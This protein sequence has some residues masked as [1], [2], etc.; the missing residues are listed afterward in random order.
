MKRLVRIGKWVLG[1]VSVAA[2]LAGCG[3][4]GGSDSPSS[5]ASAP[6]SEAAAGG[7]GAAP[8]A[9]GTAATAAGSPATA[10][11]TSTIAAS[12]KA[13][14][15]R[16]LESINAVRAVARKCGTVDYPAVG[17]VKWNT[18][19]EQASLAHAQWLQQNNAFSHSGANGSTVGDRLTATGYVWQTVGENIAA[20]YPDLASVMAGWV[21]SPGHCVNLMNSQFT[22][23]GVSLVPGASAN[24]Y[25]TYWGMVLARPR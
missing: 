7:A 14:A 16:V 23:L 3:G 18:Q 22:D 25:K 15:D 11:A 21:G 5:G 10:V 13:F 8:S 24:T 1:A 12:D 4:S 2:A 17:A 6:A 20:G 9:T 19:A